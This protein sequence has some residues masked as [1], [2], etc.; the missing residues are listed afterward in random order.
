MFVYTNFLTA[1]FFAKI[2]PEK[3]MILLQSIFHEKNGPNL[4]Y[5]KKLKKTIT[6]PSVSVASVVVSLF[7]RWCL[8]DFANSIVI[9]FHLQIIWQ[10]SE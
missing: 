3:N 2:W 5:S 1:I 9:F 8:Q 4:G 6:P 10:E 7:T